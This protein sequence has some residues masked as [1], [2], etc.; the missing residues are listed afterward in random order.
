MMNIRYTTASVVQEK[1]DVIVLC[2]YEDNYTTPIFKSIDKI[3]DGELSAHA[4]D[5]HFKASKHQILTLATA[6]RLP[7]KHIMVIGA[8]K[9]KSCLPDH[10]RHI[11]AIATRQTTQ[12]LGGE[13]MAF[14][15]PTQKGSSEFIKTVQF[16]A[17]GA[18]HGMYRFNKYISK[19]KP[20]NELQ[21]LTLVG[22]TKTSN[23]IRKTIKRAEIVSS[24]VHH[25]R[26]LI[27]EPAE[28]AT[29]SYMASVARSVAKKHGL[30]VKILDAKACEKLG[31]NMF[32]AVGRGSVEEPKLIHLTYKPKSKPKKRIVF[33][34]KGVTF[35]SGGYSLKPSASMFDMKIDMSGSAAVIAS[36]AAIASLG[37][38]Y[39]IHAVAACCENMVAGNAY[40]LG[41]ILTA[42]DGT[43]VEI[44]NTD[45]EGRLTLGDAITYAKQKIEP[46]EI[47][48]F[49]TLTGAC[50]V[51]LGLDIAGVM[52]SSDPLKKR[53]L[54]AANNAGERM[55]E[56][57]LPADYI[58]ILKSPIADLRNSGGRWAGTI[59]AGLFL[60]NFAKDTPWVHVDIAG[61]A[62]SE[63]QQGATPCGGVG[64]AVAT[65]VEYA[66][67]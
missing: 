9:Q 1:T 8:G 16:A 51:A 27:N 60:Q 11:A 30:G 41:D 32:L 53:W 24:A 5:T 7:A 55:W 56:L 14:V 23:S 18:A 35:D 25:A 29:P 21:T 49:A 20:S 39:E 65:I 45:A 62:A 61:P 38:N 40:R 52:S 3:L 15:L 54:N 6:N 47:F 34:G 4:K 13:H 59:T 26:D 37:S 12:H 2:V 31:M 50:M 36:M 66:T 64:F 44:D 17:E 48:D 58:D 63:K 67:R 10:I 19:D 42:M 22:K 28:C 46:D 33:V 43:T 57:P